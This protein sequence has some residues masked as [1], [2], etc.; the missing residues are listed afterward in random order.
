MTNYVSSYSNVSKFH[1]PSPIFWRCLSSSAAGVPATAQCVPWR[2]STCTSHYRSHATC[3][4]SSSGNLTAEHAL[5]NA[6]KVTDFFNQFMAV[7]ILF[8]I[9]DTYF[10]SN[11][12]INNYVFGFWR[13][14][15]QSFTQSMAVLVF[16]FI[17]SSAMTSV[18]TRRPMSVISRWMG[19]GK[20]FL[21]TNFHNRHHRFQLTRKG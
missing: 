10:N 18:I 5:S 11:N 19:W 8:D 14:V 1:S 16:I 4:R 15:V 6:H 12:N 3:R 13:F 2:P 9:A 21:N 17:I 20:F 7:V